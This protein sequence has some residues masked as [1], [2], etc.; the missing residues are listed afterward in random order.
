MVIHVRRTR[1][2]IIVE[3]TMWPP[4]LSVAWWARRRQNWRIV[5]LERLPDLELRA[6]ARVESE[7]AH[8]FK[9]SQPDSANS[10]ARADHQ[11]Q[12]GEVQ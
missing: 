9:A 6:A 2:P 1:G 7:S 10:A 5:N 4:R 11:F 12:L 8:A 3:L